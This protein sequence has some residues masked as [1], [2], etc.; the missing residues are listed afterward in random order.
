[1]MTTT[2]DATVR[3]RLNPEL[4]AQAESVL[5]SIGMTS[6]EAIRLFYKQIATRKE[7]PLELKVPNQ[8]TIDAFNEPHEKVTLDELRGM[9]K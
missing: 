5:A 1:M 8:T 7:F 3:S 2:K 4:K 9:F 6:S